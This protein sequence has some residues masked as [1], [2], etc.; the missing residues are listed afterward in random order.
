MQQKNIAL[1]TGSSSGIGFHTSLFLARAGFYTYATMRNLDK[2]SKIIDIAQEDNLPLEVLRLDVTDDK[3]VKDVI[4]TIAVKQKRIDVVVNNAGY[5]STGAVEDFSIDEIKA[6][7]ETNFFGVIRVI[8]YVLPIMREQ[9]SGVIVN[10]SSIGG[11]IAFPFSPFYASTKFALEGLSEALQ[12]EVEQFGIKVI[13]V[14]PGI[15]K[16]NFFDNILKAKRAADPASPYSE[17]LQRRIN[18]VKTM[19]ENG[20]APEEVAKVI[21]KAITSITPDLR[22]LVGSDANSLIEKRK[23]VSERKF[24]EF[25]SQN[26]LGS[27]NRMN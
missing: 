20:T 3:S 8:Q 19:F 26:I 11:R 27:D 21:L 10:I 2:S 22:Y 15:I 1:V 17:L 13:L 6:Q 14:E 18:R 5:G 4:N 24:L 7:F 16:T 25:M 9:R 23:N 12:Y